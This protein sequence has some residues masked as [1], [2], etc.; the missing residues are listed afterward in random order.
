MKKPIRAAVVGLGRVGWCVHV[1]EM[2]KRDAFHIVSVADPS[3]DRTNEARNLLKCQT[4]PDLDSL[5]KDS[6]AELVV[7]ATPSLKHQAEV[8]QVLAAGRHCIVEK[9]MAMTYA[10]AQTLQ[11]AAQRAGRGLF[12]HHQHRLGK[13]F[14]HLREIIDGGRLGNILEIRA[15][16]GCF[17]RRHD[18]QVLRK[19]GGGELNNTVSHALSVRLPLLDAPVDALFSDLRLVRNAGDCEDHVHLFMRAR[20]GR[21][22]DLT[23]TSVCALPSPKWMILGSCGTLSSDGTTSTLRYFDP[24]KVSPVEVIDAAAPNRQYPSE[25]LPWQEESLP[26]APS[27]PPPTFY[28]NVRDVLQT[29]APMVITTESAVEVVRIVELARRG[30]AFP[31]HT[32]QELA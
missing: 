28:D 24:A 7:L 31:P 25:S 17:R 19:N 27:Q 20:N 23:V 15:H 22:A 2:R 26:T 29:N 4:Y 6:D 12:V 32:D 3:A 13:E 21:T 10:G 30:S 9:P 1:E 11:D 18:W 8:L 14:L 5:L 16:W